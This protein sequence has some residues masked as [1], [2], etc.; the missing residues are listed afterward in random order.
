MRRYLLISVF[1]I[2][3]VSIPV[4][5][6]S[7]DIVK[8]W[9]ITY[10]DEGFTPE[11]PLPT[12]TYYGLKT[13]VDT[14]INAVTYM[15]LIISS[16]SLFSQIS[17]IGGIREESG[18]IYL[19]KSKYTSEEVLLYDFSISAN[20]SVIVHR[21]FQINHFSSYATKVKVDS[22][23]TLD[24]NGEI[25]KRLYVG[26]QCI[27]YPDYDDKDIWVEGI[28]SLTNGLLNESCRCITGCYTNSY[29]T[30]YFEDDI[31]KWRDS[32]FSRCV[33]DSSGIVNTM[34]ENDQNHTKVIIRPNPVI[35][36]SSISYS[37]GFE[38]AEV[39][40]IMGRHL[41][42]YWFNGHS[43]EVSRNDYKSG[44]YSIVIRCKDDRVYSQKLIVK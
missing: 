14:S 10:N 29:L 5:S 39:Y 25:R 30:C 32:N 22:V 20:D 26:Y 24:L 7:Q 23:N 1:P 16:D 17:T 34:H 38:L 21:L 43:I 28:G 2:L 40:D 3:L 37:D 13:E 4:C 6:F 42:T 33:I 12:W 44:I 35:D 31:L 15:K 18:K 36:I 11:H 9:N 19:S 8:T 41:K 27:G